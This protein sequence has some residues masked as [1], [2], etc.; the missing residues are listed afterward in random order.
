MWLHI[1]PQE[2]GFPEGKAAPLH[3]E[4]GLALHNSSLHDPKYTRN[5]AQSFSSIWYQFNLFASPASSAIS[6]A[7][8]L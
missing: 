3:D 6:G 4:M 7:P 2:H 1:R 8:H 5:K